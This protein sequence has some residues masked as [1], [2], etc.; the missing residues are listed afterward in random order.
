MA[1]HCFELYINYILGKD[2]CKNFAQNIRSC[3]TKL[4]LLAAG[5]ESCPKLLPKAA[6]QSCSQSYSPALLLKA[7]LQS[8]APKLF[9]KAIVPK[10]LFCKSVR[11]NGPPKLFHKATPESYA[12]ARARKGNK[13]SVC[14]RRRVRQAGNL[15]EVHNRKIPLN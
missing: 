3:L 1:L 10:L 7:V 14:G 4:L 13:H 9:S 2:L 8:C 15:A 12:T 6:P 11:Q 5:P